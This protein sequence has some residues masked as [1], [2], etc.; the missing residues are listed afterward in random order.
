MLVGEGR[1]GEK[2]VAGVGEHA[3]DFRVGA[4]Q[5]P[6]H[7]V[8]LGVHMFLIRLGE[9]RADDRGHH[10]ARA[11][12]DHRE[13]V[14]HEMD[15]AALPR[16]TLQHDRGGFLDVTPEPGNYINLQDATQSVSMMG[17]KK[18]SRG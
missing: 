7:L 1:E 13:H 3:C 6:G 18:S 8:E 14:A 4:L 12:R 5:H 10:L 15:P 11:F 17:I 2:A 9:D 16:G